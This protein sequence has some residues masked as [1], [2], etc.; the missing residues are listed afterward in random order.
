MINQV[1]RGTIAPIARRHERIQD[2]LMV[3]SFGLWALL[4]GMA[5][6]LIYSLLMRS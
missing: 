5:P 1:I 6:V 3:S 4:L 2:L